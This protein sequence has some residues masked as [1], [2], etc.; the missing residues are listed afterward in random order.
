M[1]K[2]YLKVA[3]RNIVKHKF[4]SLIIIAGLSVGIAGAILIFLYVRHEWS[5]DDFH[6][7][8]GRIHRLAVFE[9]YSA[10]QQF[11]NTLT[12]F[13]LGP[14]LKEA[15]PEVVRYARIGESS[16][17]VRRGPNSHL[18][19]FSVADP[20]LFEMF[21][22][23][24]VKG[25]P[26]T[27]L[28]APD[29]V[30]LTESMALKYFGREDP[31]GQ[32][33]SINLNGKPND[34]RVSAVAEDVP[35][36][37]SIKFE[38]LIS[39]AR[40]KDLWRERSLQNWFSVNHETY[41][42]LAPGATPQSLE[43]KLDLVSRV[44]LGNQYKPGV[45]VVRVQPLRSIHL[46]TSFPAGLQP[47]SDPANS[48]ILA[49]IALLIL[50]IAGVNFVTLSI[51]RSAPRAR[52]VGIRKVVGADRRQLMRQYWG[53]ALLVSFFS[54]IL[55]IALAELFLPTF[56]SLAGKN[57]RLDFSWPTVIASLATMA[58][59]GLAAGIYP[60][61]L[62]SGFQAVE[63]LKGKITIEKNKLFRRALV[64]FQFGLSIFLIVCALTMS[65]Q[66]HFLRQKNL[67]FRGEQVVVV[68][69]HAQRPE[70]QRLV[71]LFRE[72]VGARPDVVSVAGISYAFGSG[73]MEVGFTADDGVYKK[74]FANFVTHEFLKTMGI[75]L[76][77]GRDFSRD[78]PSDEREGVLVNETFVREFK[79]GTAVGGRLPG[80][81]FPA[82]QII[83]VVKDFHFTSLHEP[84]APLILAIDP[85]T[86]LKGVQDVNVSSSGMAK[87]LA[88]VRPDNIP[89]AVDRLQAAW[90]KISP[91]IP[92]DF[93]F[94]DEDFNRQYQAD[95]RWGKIVSISTLFSLLI[96]G[97]GLFGL[98]S[99]AI[100]QRTKEIGVRKVLGSTV[101]G[102]VRLLS[103]DF[104]KLVLLSN[105]VAWPLAYF[106]MSRWLQA[107][108]YRIQVNA[109]VFVLAAALAV[110]LAQ[111]AIIFQ[112]VK[113]ASAN[114]VEALKYE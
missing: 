8:G 109:A 45:F 102:L 106:A 77:A 28:A 16:D 51:G 32:V 78:M 70:G 17:I 94:L 27:A 103:L 19:T 80:K 49:G 53:E 76:A 26:Q 5:Y 92:F 89:G 75:E 24:L 37:S 71:G 15:F 10:N 110:V 40:A 59:A 69:T 30:V 6:A 64:L 87:I 23:P 82:H 114:P 13:P 9:N 113:A 91:G 83:G 44:A 100:A 3:L 25:T 63:V 105:L 4:Y 38:M 104:V 72:D 29:S 96:A 73:W 62:L 107:F 35:E 34:F 48:Y 65:R 93:S 98:S 111:A 79:L 67:G 41:V 20:S 47:T 1:L 86:V 99:L 90:K 11:F 81:N 33:L 56:R 43:P 88:R 74:A 7:R 108:A 39:L 54:L 18:E 85:N 21:T 58:V 95:Q 2:N 60:A 112:A 22:F 61:A 42:E 36:N 57:L 68:Q 12:P 14:A 55:A 66:L 97:L 31:I 46:D 50:F 52:E 84:I 101:P